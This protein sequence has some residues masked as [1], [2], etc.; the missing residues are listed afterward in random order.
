MTSENN[1]DLTNNFAIIWL[2]GTIEK[3]SGNR[4]T[5]ALLRQLV[6]CRLLTFD[7]PDKCIDHISDEPTT[8]RVFLIVSNAFGQKVIPLIHDLPHLQGTYIFCG[9]QKS[10]EIWAKPYSKVS[11]IFTR[12]AELLDKIGND[13]GMLN[14]DEDLPMSIFH[15]TEQENSL[16]QL[17]KESTTFMWYRLILIVLRLIAK[18]GDSK[19]E[20]IA[21][22]RAAYHN[23][24]AEQKKINDFERNYCA[25]EIFSWYTKDSFAFR[26]LNKALRTQNI[27]V[28]FK[29]RFFINDLHNQIEQLYHRYLEDHSS[30]IDH[31]DIRV[32]RGQR[33]NMTEVDI[34]KRNVNELISMNSFLSTT[35]NKKLAKV[36]AG[37]NDQSNE[38][39]SLQSVLF[40]IDICNM[41]KEMAPFAI[42]EN[43]PCSQDN[44][45]EEVLFSICAIFQIRSVKQEDDM[46]YVHLQLTKEQNELSQNLSK[47]MMNQISSEPDPLSFGWF[48]FRMSDYDKAERYTKL[49]LKQLPSN[50]KGIG[51][52]YNLIGL[53]Y[54]DTHRLEQSVEC[55]EKALDI[56]TQLN[57][58]NSLQVIATHY[59]LGLVYL[60]LGE[61]RNAEDQQIQAEEKF[62]NSSQ[63]KDSLVI[64][65]IKGLKAKIQAEYGNDAN[66]LKILELVLKDKMQRLPATHPSIASTSN[67]IGIVYEKM[68]NNVKALEYFRKALEIGKKGLTINHK[69]LAEY[70]TNI[71]RIYDKQK[72][73]QLALQQYELS[74]EIMENYRD[75]EYEKISILNTNIIEMKNKLHLSQIYG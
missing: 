56:Y 27:E 31:H 38:S 51:D 16:Q 59:N 43:S 44:G 69:D 11:G 61:T 54:Y 2:D 14:K 47:Y 32:Y 9:D 10:A 62:F 24:E 13:V 48:L 39:S 4:E 70:H 60:T 72:Q 49:M 46:W 15:L 5:K 37:T 57:C 18:F 71:A 36:F 20:M 75:E 40:I 28:I 65:A 6:K 7:D 25:K 74:L 29:F 58:Y 41:N 42:L 23:N 55:Y 1:N 45:E 17:S 19:N 50:D 33:L 63:P 12:R 21:E 26:L 67:T 73:F 3:T 66:A 8:K 35:F 22:C 68:D 53:I 34:L 52:A 64:T 30:S